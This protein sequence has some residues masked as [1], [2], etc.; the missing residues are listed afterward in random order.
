VSPRK[1]AILNHLAAL[2]MTF[3][4]GYVAAAVDAG[5]PDVPG[6][7]MGGLIY[8]ALVSPLFLYLFVLFL[9]GHEAKSF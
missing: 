4:C 8:V 3:A 9:T 6:P 1:K 7:I 2:I 5:K